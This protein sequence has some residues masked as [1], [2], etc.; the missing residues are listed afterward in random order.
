[1]QDQQGPWRAVW[2][3][4]R[5]A[6]WLDGCDDA[7]VDQLAAASRLQQYPAGAVVAMRGDVAE[8]LI[9]VAEGA[10]EIGM[11]NVSG[12][13]HVTSWLG[14]GQLFGLIPVL[15]N[16]QMIHTATATRPSR[17]LLLP[18]AALMQA[19]LDHPSLSLRLIY[20]VCQRARGQYE[21]LAAQ[22]LLTLPVRL[23]R[24]LKGQVADRPDGRITAT[25]TDLAD[26]L[27]VTRQCL[28]QELRKLERE[29]MLLLGRGQI[30]VLDRA[31]LDR[32]AGGGE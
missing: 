6:P 9:V 21:L 30:Q 8:H 22:S 26:V 20:L 7:V 10:I 23:M 16:G 28:N 19:L 17:L 2:H 18:R 14:R 27:G 24:V 5:T 25:Q 13:R 15:E 32:G 1:M 31:A 12:K 11:T 4:L 3:A 29:G